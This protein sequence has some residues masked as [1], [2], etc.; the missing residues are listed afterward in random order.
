MKTILLLL[1][2]AFVAPAQLAITVS[3]V[4]VTGQKVV[5][6]L[7]IENKFSEK[8]ESAR[9][10]VFLLDG[11]GKAIGQP[12]TRWVIGGVNTNGLAAGGT[13]TFHFVITSDRPLTITNLAAQVSFS[14]V[15]LEGGKLADIKKDVQIRSR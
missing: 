2:T 5:V 3:P 11:Q 13:N 4:R 12:T 6:P 1:I 15:V 8:I 7:A 10:V 9:A 14:R